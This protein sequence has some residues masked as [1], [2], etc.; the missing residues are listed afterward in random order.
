MSSNATIQI[1]GGVR[2]VVPNSLHLITPY[3]LLE[4]QDWFEDEIK[5]LRRLL[6]PGQQV[7]DIGANHGVYSLSM[8]QTVGPM[9]R[10]WAFEPA[11]ATARLLAESIS[12]NGFT[13]VQLEV[14]ALSDHCGSAT[15]SLNTNSELNTLVSEAGA[16]GATETVPLL[17]LDEC[18]TRQAWRGIDFVKIDAEGEESRILAGG[19]R[20]FAEQS[21]LVQY[22]VKAGRDL[23]LE[24]VQQFAALGYASYRL[25]PGLDL[26]VPFDAQ[27]VP[28]AYLLNLFCCKADRA[29]LLAAQ[30]VLFDP[31]LLTD[32]A[33]AAPSLPDARQ[34]AAEPSCDWR[35]TLGRLPYGARFVPHWQ[36]AATDEGLADALGLYALAQDA[37][38]PVGTRFLALE[39]SLGQFTACSARQPQRLHWASVARVAAELGARST[40]VRA[41]QHLSTAMQQG[42]PLDASQPFLAPSRRFDAVPPGEAFGNWVLAAATEELERLGSYSSFYTGTSARPRLE[43]IH[44]IGLGSDEMKRRLQLV[45]MRFNLAAGPT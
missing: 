30:G 33:A 15:L 37:G 41:L 32:A 42:Q 29:L 2:I 20:F 45:Q 10:V 38:Q 39:A 19:T 24:L 18:M 5:F 16:G 1:T 44:A 3:V 6:Q 43:L 7:V 17:T 27:A 25:V 31:A 35:L 26:L 28:D 23:H 22:E 14:S 21:P 8:A 36:V 11:S 13:H 4:Q 12:T 40:A 34:R 9:G